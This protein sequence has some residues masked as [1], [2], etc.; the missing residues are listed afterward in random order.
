MNAPF[1]YRWTHPTIALI[2]S[3]LKNN[4]PATGADLVKVLRCGPTHI[5]D[6]CDW[7]HKRHLIRIAAWTLTLRATTRVWHLADGTPDAIR[8]TRNVRL[9]VKH[10]RNTGRSLP[11]ELQ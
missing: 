1:A 4:G 11:L 3:H 7:M 10:R 8:K 5:L 6:A 2:L 9:R